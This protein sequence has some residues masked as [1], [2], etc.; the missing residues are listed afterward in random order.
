MRRNGN[1]LRDIHLTKTE[2]GGNKISE[3]T[4]K[5]IESVIRKSATKKIGSGQ[6]GDVKSEH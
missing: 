4:G 2:S 5:K 1:F 6:T 3:Q